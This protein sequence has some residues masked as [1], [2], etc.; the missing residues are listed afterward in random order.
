[1]TWV[2]ALPSEPTGPTPSGGQKTHLIARGQ[3]CRHYRVHPVECAAADEQDVPGVDLEE[4][5]VRV[6]APSLGRDV[7]NATFDDLEEF[8]L[9]AFS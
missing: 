5:L 2:I 3:P 8:L 6:F 1:M 7:G 4:F 9:D